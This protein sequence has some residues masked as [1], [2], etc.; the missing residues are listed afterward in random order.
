MKDS[1]R[2][3]SE[4]IQYWKKGLMMGLI[5]LGR[6]QKLVDDGEAF[7]INDQASGAIINGKKEA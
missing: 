5:P 6:A 2:L 7:V 4:R 3:T 1:D